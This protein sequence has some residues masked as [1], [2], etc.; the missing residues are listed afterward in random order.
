M[1]KRKQGSTRPADRPSDP[2]GTG[3]RS[4][5]RSRSAGAAADQR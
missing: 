1:S 4:F 2:W 5:I 3:D